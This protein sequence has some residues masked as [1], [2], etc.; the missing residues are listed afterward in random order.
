MAASSWRGGGVKDCRTTWLLLVRRTE[1][2]HAVLQEG[3]LGKLGASM[4]TAR[5]QGGDCQ[6]CVNGDPQWLIAY[7]RWDIIGDGLRSGRGAWMTR[8]D[9]CSAAVVVRRPRSF[10]GRP[11]GARWRG[12]HATLRLKLSPVRLKHAS[13]R[14]TCRGHPSF[15]TAVQGPAAGRTSHEFACGTNQV[16]GSVLSMVLLKRLPTPVAM[17]TRHIVTLTARHGVS[18]GRAGSASRQRAACGRPH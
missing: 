5:A 9:D 8:V 16:P 14:H 17:F 15:D 10:A 6:V 12:L 2:S 18:T 4:L 11:Q 7:G 1:S 3:G 13:L